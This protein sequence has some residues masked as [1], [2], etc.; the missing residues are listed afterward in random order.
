VFPPA[1]E[2][3]HTGRWVMF[4]FI[5]LLVFSY[6]NGGFVAAGIRDFLIAHVLTPIHLNDEKTIEHFANVMAGFEE[7][8]I[9]WLIIF[10][11]YSLAKSALGFTGEKLRL[12]A[13][14]ARPL[15][16]LTGFS[17]TALCPGDVRGGLV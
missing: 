5:C 14:H 17:G 7:M 6:F 3:R 12:L 15:Q 10:F 1:P 9:Y 8:V 16:V 11:F 13:Q 4:A 2:R